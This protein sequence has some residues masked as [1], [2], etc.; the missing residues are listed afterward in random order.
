MIAARS[1]RLKIECIPCLVDDLKGAIQETV[2]DPELQLAIMAHGLAWLAGNLS[3]ERIPSYYITELHRLLK[4]HSGI[5]TPFKERR[6]A[7]NRVGMELA[8]RLEQKASQ[9]TDPQE[10][11][12]FLAR[13]CVAGNHLDFRTVGTGYGFSIN[14]IESMLQQVVDQGLAVDDTGALGKICRQAKT[15]LYLCDNVGEIALDHLLIRELKNYG[16]QITAAVKGGPITSDATMEDAI[17]VG[18]SKSVP[19]ILTG[20]DTLGLSPYELSP[21]VK[22]CLYSSDLIIS[23]GQANFYALT[24]LKDLIPG[25]IAF[26]LRTKCEWISNLLG[27]EAGTNIV[28]IA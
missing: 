14:A 4:E 13:W 9:I 22:S 16:C 2:S 6:D 15:I 21:E 3:F 5:R 8:A 20:A 23:K 10:K 25:T 28:K 17:L 11:L 7:C 26:L 19:V 12:A 27:A 24:E 18:L 1:T